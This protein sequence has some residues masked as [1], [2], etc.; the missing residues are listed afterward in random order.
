MWKIRHGSHAGSN[1]GEV[2][3][4]AVEVDGDD[5][6]V[7]IR[8]PIPLDLKGMKVYSVRD[9]GKIVKHIW[10]TVPPGAYDGHTYHLE[11]FRSYLRA[12]PLAIT[13]WF[14]FRFGQKRAQI[15]KLYAGESKFHLNN[16]GTVKLK[17]VEDH[18][19]HC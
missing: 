16:G 10:G 9:D 1:A 5:V 11:A 8:R 13:T 18:N 19:D 3:G 2:D 12:L 6:T 14:G 4:N 17:I 7:T 15:P